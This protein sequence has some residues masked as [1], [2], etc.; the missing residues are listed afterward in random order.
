MLII[1]FS[2]LFGYIIGIISEK[3]TNK[4]DHQ[5]IIIQILKK[6]EY[7]G[8]QCNF[9]LQT[10]LVYNNEECVFYRNYLLTDENIKDLKQI[11]ADEKKIVEDV[12]ISCFKGK[13]PFQEW[14]LE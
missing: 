7:S 8:D 1:L 4:T 5:Y 2:F 13:I 11:K 14:R 12:Y 3:A 9:T 6:E 10:G